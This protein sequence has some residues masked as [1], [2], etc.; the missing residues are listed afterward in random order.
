MQQINR[1]PC[2][3]RRRGHH[4]SACH[5]RQTLLQEP[6]RANFTSPSPLLSSTFANHDYV[7]TETLQT[8]ILVR[9]ASIIAC[10]HTR[11]SAADACDIDYTQDGPKQKR[12]HS[13]HQESTINIDASSCSL[14]HACKKHWNNRS[15]MNHCQSQK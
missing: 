9:I 15:D 1:Y 8:A 2:N 10:M 7:H 13:R 14:K 5:V 6:S 4:T 3:V 12:C 11:G